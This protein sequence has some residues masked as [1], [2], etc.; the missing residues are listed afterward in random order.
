MSTADHWLIKSNKAQFDCSDG[1]IYLNFINK[2]STDKF[3]K[4]LYN[5]TTKRYDKFYIDREFSY[6]N[7]IYIGLRY[8]PITK[9][10]ITDQYQLN[11][12]KNDKPP[13][14]KQYD[15]VVLNTLQ[16]IELLKN[17]YYLTKDCDI[18]KFIEHFK[19]DITNNIDQIIEGKIR[20]LIYVFNKISIPETIPETKELI[21]DAIKKLNCAADD[22][23]HERLVETKKKVLLKNFE[24]GQS[25]K[26][27]NVIEHNIAFHN[28]DKIKRYTGA[29]AVYLYYVDKDDDV[30]FYMPNLDYNQA[31]TH[32]TIIFEPNFTKEEGVQ[33]DK[34]KLILTKA[35][36][37]GIPLNLL[38]DQIKN[39]IVIKLFTTAQLLL[40]LNRVIYINDMHKNRTFSLINPGDNLK[41]DFI[42]LF[43]SFF[44][45][46][47][48]RIF[49]NNIKW[50]CIIDN[51]LIT[52]T[53][54]FI[55]LIEEDD[56]VIKK[57]LEIDDNEEHLYEFCKNSVLHPTESNAQKINDIRIEYENETV[58]R[59]RIIN[60][61][62]ELCGIM[63]TDDIA[64]E[65]LKDIKLNEKERFIKYLEQNNI[66]DKI[67]EKVVN[68]IFKV[69]K[70]SKPEEKESKPEEKDDIEERLRKI[71]GMN[72]KD[73]IDLISKDI[74]NIDKLPKIPS[75]L[76]QVLPF[77]LRLRI[78]RY[79]HDQ[80]CI[81]KIKQVEEKIGKKIEKIDETIS[82]EELKQ[83]YSI[84]I[85]ETGNY[86]S[87][88]REL[89]SFL[90]F[91][92]L[93]YDRKIK[94]NQ[95]II[96]ATGLSIN[97]INSL[98][99]DDKKSMDKIN[100]VLDDSSGEKL[101]KKYI[102]KKI[103]DMI[104]SYKNN[105][106]KTILKQTGYTI[107]QIDK[108]DPDTDSAIIKTK[109][110][111]RLSIS[112]QK[113]LYDKLTNPKLKTLLKSVI[114][115]SSSELSGGRKNTYDMNQNIHK[116]Y[117]SY[118]QK[119]NYF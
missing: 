20:W 52:Q 94:D 77:P 23:L 79:L 31:L 40:M 88:I 9:N 86:I 2:L 119:Y 1:Q 11:I 64:T 26:F 29:R 58:E 15:L 83:I 62:N 54:T 95:F 30:D 111:Y 101:I 115:E 55:N 65:I 105:P 37:E 56:Y 117:L 49:R 14:Y 16:L 93:A 18:C 104:K 98:T 4:L 36:K 74:S 41:T 84:L 100:E 17:V 25:D 97:E 51:N 66:E 13:F 12:I 80:E 73:F 69:K 32:S 48:P 76:L 109:I 6:N 92:L 112:N 70:E 103:L 90:E 89:N 10:Y 110:F 24:R 72:V 38:S 21:L 44:E 96:E 67:I 60:I 8:N 91:K 45:S 99:P 61:L 116:K 50:A 19:T 113:Y 28:S 43:I 46:N 85:D 71:V 47:K 78:K 82:E 63:I 39:K 87:C 33:Y 59:K 7:S 42:E 22:T 81:K 114:D 34:Y 102:N 118:M 68:L 75:E 35:N 53:Q 106:E 27:G 3:R 57:L 107:E 108:L 5:E